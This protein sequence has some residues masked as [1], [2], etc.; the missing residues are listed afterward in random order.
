MTAGSHGD[1]APFT[2]LGHGLAQAGHDVTLVTHARFASMA[3]TAG[4]GFHALP[5]DPHAE[6]HSAQ[7]QA[8][9]RQRH[10]R[11]Q[12]SETCLSGP[13]G[14]RRDGRRAAR[15]RRVQ[16]CAAAVRLTG[17]HRTHH[18]RGTGACGHGCLPAAT[19]HHRRVPAPGGRH[20]LMPSNGEPVRRTSRWR[21]PGTR[22][23]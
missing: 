22:F 11:R 1:V 3:V 6:L 23:R 8:P 18:R 16:R 9:A 13:E 20:P 12:A 14:A 7:G 17:P 19:V 15:G 5:V 2:G 10:W 4:I 21:R